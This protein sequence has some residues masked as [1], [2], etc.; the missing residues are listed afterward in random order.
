MSASQNTQDSVRQL[1]ALCDP[2]TGSAEARECV[3]FVTI[4]NKAKG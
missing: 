3:A 2:K 4:K 1:I